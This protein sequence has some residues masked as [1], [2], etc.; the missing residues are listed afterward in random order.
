VGYTRQAVAIGLIMASIVAWERNQLLRFAMCILVAATFHKTAVLALPLVA[1]SSKRNRFV[2][3]IMVLGLALVLFRFFLAESVDKM[4]TNYVEAEYS[5]QGAAVRVSMNVLP[6]VLFLM[7]QRRFGLPDE[8]RRMWRNFAYATLATVALLLTLPSSTV[9][10]RIALY[11]I[12]IQLFVFSRL[13]YVFANGGKPNGQM[14][15]LVIA[16]AATILFVWL[17]YATHAEYWVPYASWPLEGA[18]TA[19]NFDR[20]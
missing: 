7:F 2:T 8:Q 4:V 3:G 6:A 17:N 13:P 1:M 12:P 5:S 18:E 19:P 9:V 16:Y 11:L 20:M 14:I 15:L 10:D